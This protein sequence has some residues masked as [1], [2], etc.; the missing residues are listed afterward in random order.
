MASSRPRSRTRTSAA[1]TAAAAALIG[2]RVVASTK[3]GYNSNIKQLKSYYVEE[4]R[5]RD[6][7]LPVRLD[8]VIG[9][10][11]WLVDSK[12]KDKPA[13]PSTI[14]A[15]KSALLWYHAEHKQT[16]N[17]HIDREIELLLKGY[18]RRVADLKAA[19]K[20]AVFEGKYHLPY[21]GY[22][23]VAKALFSCTPFSQMLFGWPFL[24]LQWNL[25]ARSATVAGMMMEHVGWEGDAL[26]ISTPKH[27]ADQEGAHCFSRHLYANASR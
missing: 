22:C 16:L 20:M 18:Q 27:K 24:V 15:Y 19:G 14:R 10:F 26:L 2:A 23:I 13:A 9:F 7:I 4:L 11:G 8:D 17:S 3:K 25:I 21:D 12:F 5:C 6:I 1:S